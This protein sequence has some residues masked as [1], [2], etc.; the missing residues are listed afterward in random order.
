MLC[1][2][3]FIKVEE[4]LKRRHDRKQARLS[5]TWLGLLSLDQRR[6]EQS[7]RLLGDELV[8]LQTLASVLETET[9]TQGYQKTPRSALQSWLTVVA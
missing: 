5:R 8:K 2:A 1:P 6:V 9:R 4:I 3:R 7:V